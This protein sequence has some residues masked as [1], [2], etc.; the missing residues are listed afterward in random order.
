MSLSWK[1]DKK[2]K[3]KI[4]LLAVFF[5]FFPRKRPGPYKTALTAMTT[6]RGMH[7]VVGFG[8]CFWQKEG[9]CGLYH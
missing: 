6:L 3:P 1:V 4:F 2:T 8:F 7:P 5:V 9:F